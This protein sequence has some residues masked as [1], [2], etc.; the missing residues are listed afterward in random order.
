MPNMWM[1]RAG[2]DA[3]LIDDFKELNIVAIGWGMWDLSGKTRK[4][5]KSIME[6]E[7]PE[8]NKT[9]LSLNASQ[10]SRFV[11]DFEIGDWI[12]SYNPQT[13]NYLVGKITS[14]YY[15]SKKL[16]KK[17]KTEDEFFNHTRDVEW[18]GEACKNDLNQ[19]TLKPLKS[20]MTLF[21]LY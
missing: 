6:K 7:Y 4:E 17:Y 5:I 11:C 20:I 14:D 13:M 12:I 2:E 21:S 19:N 16:A 9:S 18:I 1:V 3:F 10:V 8:Y 15:Y